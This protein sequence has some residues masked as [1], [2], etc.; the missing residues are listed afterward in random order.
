[1]KASIGDTVVV[2]SAVVAGAVREGKVVELRHPDGTP[3][4]V[5]EWRDSG[6]RTLVFPGPDTLVRP[7][8]QSR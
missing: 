4:Y 5:V 6:E 1:M 8:K 2:K 3:P 7:A